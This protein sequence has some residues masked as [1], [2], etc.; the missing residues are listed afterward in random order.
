MLRGRHSPALSVYKYGFESVYELRVDSKL[1]FWWFN[2]EIPT[3]YWYARRLS[4]HGVEMISIMYETDVTQ[5]CACTWD[6]SS[7][8]FV[9][10]VRFK[11]SLCR[12]GL[13]III[14]KQT[15]SGRHL[16]REKRENG[17][18]GESTVWVWVTFRGRLNVYCTAWLTGDVTVLIR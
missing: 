1:M 16:C 8:L 2:Q 12:R 15:Y 4:R 9:F 5:L 3:K 11:Y 18:T 14:E 10:K 6:F 7:F 13:Q 17:E